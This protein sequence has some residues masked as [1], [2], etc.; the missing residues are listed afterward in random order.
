VGL[1]EAGGRWKRK[2]QVGSL[3]MREMKRLKVEDEKKM[4]AIW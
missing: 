3:E 1:L 4:G 2:V